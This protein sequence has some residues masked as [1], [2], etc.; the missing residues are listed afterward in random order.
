MN[1]VVFDASLQKLG[2]VFER[3]NQF[4]SVVTKYAIAKHV[5]IEMN[6]NE[7]TIVL[8]FYLLALI[9]GQTILLYR[10]TIQFTNVILLIGISFI[11]SSYLFT[12]M[13]G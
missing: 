2:L 1:I 9:L 12:T 5:A 10:H 4:R 11:A 13:K 8:G 3:V 6:I 7:P